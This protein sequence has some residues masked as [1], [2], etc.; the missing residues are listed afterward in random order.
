MNR[1][2]RLIAVASIMMLAIA[3]C[4]KKDPSGTGEVQKGGNLILGAEQFPDCLNVIDTCSNASWLHWTV[5]QLVVPKA[6]TLDP[7]SNF[8]PSP[9]LVEAPTLENGGLTTEPFTVTFKIN[10]DAVWDDGTPITSEDFEF[11]WHAV[12]ETTGTLAT[13][14]YDKIRSVDT[15]DPKTAVVEFTEVYADW[16]DLFGGVSTNGYVLPKHMFPDGPDTGGLMQDMIDFSGGPWK[17]T[18]FTADEELVF[19][20]NDAYWGTK[21][22]ADQLTIVAREDQPTEL[23]SL[24]TSEVFAIYP[25]PAGVPLAAEFDQ[26]GISSEFGAGTTYEGLW[27]N[28][29]QPPMDDPAVRQAFA[30]GIDRQAIID[31]IVKPDNP[32]ATVLNCA[33]WVPTVSDWCDDTDYA[34]YTYQPDRSRELLVEAG[35]DCPA[36]EFCTKGGERLEIVIHTTAGN[37]GRA[38]TLSIAK[39]NAVA[40]GIFIDI[41][42]LASP[43]PIFTDFL[44]T[45]QHMVAL[46]ANVASPDPSVTSFLSCD[47]IPDASGSG[48]QNWS[49]W[50]NDEATAA[51]AAADQELDHDTRRDLLNTVGD[52]EAADIPWIPLYQ[53]PLITAWR[54]DKIGGPIGAYTSTSLSAFYNVHEW[55]VIQ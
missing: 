22:N 14:G 38:D 34:D 1:S 16:P 24:F 51:L 33:G 5:A 52:L 50:C 23:Q 3:A 12:L 7:Q 54:D 32:E 19:V 25:Q 29:E 48:G 6:M 8:I 2:T 18:K 27:I 30:Y 35:Y 15:S 39:E 37:Q 4:S 28:M 42:T 44:P 9:L 13:L 26:P 21:P 17:L 20:P 41:K 55:Y 31:T 40:A 36:E 45:R 43:S 11:T 53:K 49:G 10:P 46:F 47:Q